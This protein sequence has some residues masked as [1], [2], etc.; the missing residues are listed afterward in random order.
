MHGLASGDLNGDGFVDIVSVSNL[1][2]PEPFPIVPYS[3]QWGSDADATAFFFP[4]FS[5]AGQAGFVWNGMEPT[6]GDL[7]VEVSSAD[8]GNHWAS[9]RLMGT[10]GL[11]S[12]GKVNRDGIGAVVSFTPVNG[13]TVMRPVLGGA[14]YA[15]QDSLTVNL[16]L[17]EARKGVVEVL[18]PGGVRNRFYGLHA[19]EQLVLPEIPCSYDADWDSKRDYRHCVGQALKELYRAG[20]LDKSLGIRL[21]RSAML[22][23]HDARKHGERND[24]D[25]KR[26]HHRPDAHSKSGAHRQL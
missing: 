5:P 26:P 13:A 24:S 7:A 23:L 8:N 3:T 21:M 10:A 11:T 18:W 4:S 16:G 6:D 25:G 1:S 17:G 9:V 20:K 15:S 19:S 14:S 12:H 2:L 22:A